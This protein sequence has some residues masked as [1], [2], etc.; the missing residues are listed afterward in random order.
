MSLRLLVTEGDGEPNGCLQLLLHLAEAVSR[1]GV[2]MGSTEPP[3]GHQLMS[4]S[5]DLA[6]SRAM[7][8]S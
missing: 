8:I 6:G 4:I 1:T 7:S 5:S 3:C 2:A